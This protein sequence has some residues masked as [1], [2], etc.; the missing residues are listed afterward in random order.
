[1]LPRHLL[2]ELLPPGAPI[3]IAHGLQKQLQTQPIAVSEFAW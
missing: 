2:P 1:M 3:S